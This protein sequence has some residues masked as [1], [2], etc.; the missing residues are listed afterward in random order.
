MWGNTVLQ[1]LVLFIW[2]ETNGEDR[3]VSAGEEL[4]IARNAPVLNCR[5]IE[6]LSSLGITL[7]WG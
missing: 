3:N 5:G 6:H 1:F 4:N 7:E 2:V